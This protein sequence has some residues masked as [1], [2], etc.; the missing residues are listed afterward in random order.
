MIFPLHAGLEPFL[1]RW[2]MQLRVAYK[3]WVET[4]PSMMMSSTDLSLLSSDERTSTLIQN[5]L[6]QECYK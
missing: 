4:N 5:L 2:P 3:Y 1:P 6:N